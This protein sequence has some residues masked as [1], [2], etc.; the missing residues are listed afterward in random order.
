MTRTLLIEDDSMLAEALTT[1]LVRDGADVVIAQEA[2]VAKVQLVDHN[3]DVVLL[4]LGLPDGSGLDIL[5]FMRA[6][7]D[8]TP[9]II[10]TSRDR[11]SERIAGLDAGAD[12]Y[13]VKPFPVSELL[14]R[15]RAVVRR[16]KGNVAPVMSCA[17]LTL[18]PANHFATLHG[19]EVLLSSH[20]FRTLQAL[21]QRN[22]HPV[23]RETLELEVYGTS[24]ATGSNTVAVYVHQLRRKVGGDLI[25]TV[26]GFGYRLRNDS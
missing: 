1:T 25:Q 14:A 22:G 3:F 18:H 15:M 5:R 2:A 26:H 9:V 23:S 12:D 16:S 11:L 21:V 24:G 4:D 8:I 10:M 20:E 6:R 17:G 7:Y 19:K 13:V